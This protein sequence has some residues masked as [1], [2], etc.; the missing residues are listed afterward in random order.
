MPRPLPQILTTL[1][2][3]LTTAATHADVVVEAETNIRLDNV[4]VRGIENGNLLYISAGRQQ[5]TPLDRVARIELDQFP[6]YAAAQ[7]ALDNNKPQQAIRAATPE[8]QKARDTWA[9]QLILVTLVRAHDAA[10]QPV[11]A[12]NRYTQLLN[13]NPDPWFYNQTPANSVANAPANR[14]A[15]ILTR[16]RTAKQRAPRAAHAAIDP[17]IAAVSPKPQTPADAPANNDPAGTPAPPTG[18]PDTPAPTGS[19]SDSAVVLPN[20]L[21]EDL[22]AVQALRA[23]D[24][25]TALDLTQRMVNSPRDLARNLYLLGRAQLAKADAS[26]NPDDYKTAGLTFM[27]VIAHYNRLR[28]GIVGA[29]LAEVG[30]IHIKLDKPDIAQ[31][32]FQAATPLLAEDEE[33]AYFNRLSELRAQLP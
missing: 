6:G 7:D 10:N 19:V 16:L 21:P 9:R 22:K 17:L 11:A 28:N 1:L 29:S 23:G 24:F 3:T 33:P 12:V 5:S 27:R 18:T 26:G 31:T 32:L 20:G 8:V 2:L 25:D 30:Y 13:T 14:H 4:I 15:N